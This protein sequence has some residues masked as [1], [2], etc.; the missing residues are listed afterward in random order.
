M[1]QVIYVQINISML[2]ER[3][4]NAD[5][6]EFVFQKQTSTNHLSALHKNELRGQMP[7]GMASVKLKNQTYFITASAH[8]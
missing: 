8:L 3:S 2:M 6:P 5:L 1:L 7:T 4:D